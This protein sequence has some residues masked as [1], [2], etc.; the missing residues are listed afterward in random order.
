MLW[1]YV[2]I[3]ARRSLNFSVPCAP[4]STPQGY[5]APS[6]CPHPMMRMFPLA[7]ARGTLRWALLWS[8]LLASFPVQGS[9]AVLYNI[10]LCGNIITSI[11][12]L[13]EGYF[14]SWY[15]FV[16]Y[17]GHA[18]TFKVQDYP[19]YLLFWAVTAE[20]SVDSLALL[21]YLSPEQSFV[22]VLVHCT[23]MLSV[24]DALCSLSLRQSLTG[25]SGVEFYMQWASCCLLL[26]AHF[27]HVT[28]HEFNGMLLWSY[29]QF[30][31]TG[32]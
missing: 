12:W 28:S 30:H 19:H 4:T 16:T 17:L 8:T 3:H 29:E 7:P 18:W 32:Q 1:A 5:T 22:Q 26:C 31:T 24:Y 9:T 6:P 23:H 15:H 10:A 11:L 20:V 21:S 25:P 14:P 27:Q 13:I 2:C